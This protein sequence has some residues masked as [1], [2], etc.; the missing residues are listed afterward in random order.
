MLGLLC[1]VKRIERYV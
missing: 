1:K